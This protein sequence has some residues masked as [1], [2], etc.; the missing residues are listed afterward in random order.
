M[1]KRSMNRTM[2]GR[3]HSLAIHLLRLVRTGD[4]ALGLSTPR[5]SVLSVLVFGGSRTVG[6]LA[7]AEQVAVPTMTRLL[8]SLEAEGYV[9]RRRDRTDARV[10]R[11]T[12]LARGRRALET[13]RRAREERLRQ[14]LAGLSPDDLAAVERALNGLEKAL[15]AVP[16][17]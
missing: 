5:L 8:Q 6:E 15:R 13:G 12:A 1:R 4:T 10:V 17:G 14:L 9:R 2:A 16:A 3:L 7:A 11:V